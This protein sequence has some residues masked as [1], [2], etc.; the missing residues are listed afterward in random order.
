MSTT[1]RQ[2][3]RGRSLS[4]TNWPNWVQ[5]T[6]RVSHFPHVSC[7]WPSHILPCFSLRFHWAF[8]HRCRTL[9]KFFRKSNSKLQFYILHTLFSLISHFGFIKPVGIFFCTN[10]LVP[11]KFQFHPY[12]INHNVLVKIFTPVLLYITYPCEHFVRFLFNILCHD[13]GK[14]MLFFRPIGPILTRF[15]TE[16]ISCASPNIANC[17]SLIHIYFDLRFC[18]LFKLKN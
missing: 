15:I 8:T 1:C 4:T 16:T 18:L 10:L 5:K 6:K 12:S 14:N 11:V 3:P 9:L 7:Q 2:W 13:M 17:K